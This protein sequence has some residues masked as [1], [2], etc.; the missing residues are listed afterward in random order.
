MGQ[1]RGGKGGGTRTRGADGREEQK[2]WPEEEEGKEMGRAASGPDFKAG[3]YSKRVGQR[4]RLLYM[5]ECP[6]K[7]EINCL[8][9]L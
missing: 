3:N 6:E 2:G 5:K 7:E 1:K 9:K 4:A 8:E